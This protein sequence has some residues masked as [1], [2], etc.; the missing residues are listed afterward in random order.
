MQL[1]LVRERGE[2]A[3]LVNVDTVP[4]ERVLEQLRS[5]PHVITAKLVEL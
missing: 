4:D 2:A 5:V 3:M 1:A